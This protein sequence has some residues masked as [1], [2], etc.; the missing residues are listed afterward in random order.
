MGIIF[1]SDTGNMCKMIQEQ[2]DNDIFTSVNWKAKPSLADIHQFDTWYS[3]QYPNAT[4]ISTLQAKEEREKSRQKFL[5]GEL[6]KDE[7]QSK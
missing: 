7:P 3:K 1:K 5:I 2:K 6:Y 4:L